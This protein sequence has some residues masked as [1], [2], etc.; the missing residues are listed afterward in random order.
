[1]TTQVNVDHDGVE[2]TYQLIPCVQ[3]VRMPSPLLNHDTPFVIGMFT[4]ADIAIEFLSTYGNKILSME[5]I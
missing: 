5:E 2:F 4:D 3:L 1:M